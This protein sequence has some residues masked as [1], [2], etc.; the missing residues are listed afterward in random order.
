M[1]TVSK[2]EVTNLFEDGTTAKIVID[3]INPS[4]MTNEQI[5]TIRS[6]C[7][8]FN[9]NDGGD[10]ATKMKSKNGTNWIGIKQVKLTTTEQEV[11]W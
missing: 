11:Y 2:L 1:A 9:S 4:T 8:A 6:Q 10:L 5:E 3:N 7:I